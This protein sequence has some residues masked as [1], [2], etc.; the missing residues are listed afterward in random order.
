[1][2]RTLIILIVALVAV[3]AAY[4][5]FTKEEVVFSKETSLYKAVPVSAPVFVEVSS[6]RNVPPEN[7]VLGELS[8]FE[9]V[10]NILQKVQQS[11]KAI[12]E[13]KEIQGSWAK[14]PLILAFDFVGEDKIQPV[15]ISKIR[16]ADELEGF[17][18][19]LGE[20]M[21]NPGQEP[22]E[23]KY[24][25]HKIFSVKNAEGK[26]LSYCAARGLILLSPEAILIEK[27]LRQ[28]NSE[29]LTDIHNFNKVNKTVASDTDVAW[30]INHERFPELLA[31]V[32]NAKTTG[33]TNE[34]G[35]TVKTNLRRELLDTK[36]YA[37]WSE[38]DMRFDDENISLAGIT[39]ADD[40]LNHFVTIFSGQS[41][42]HCDAG[43]ILP[44]NAS[45]YLGITFSDRDLFFKNLLEF[46][47][48]SNTFYKR[49]ELLKK[50]ER[51]LGPDSRET[52]KAM[53]KNEV[54]AALTDV[55]AEG[56]PGSLFI[57]NLNSRKNSQENFESLLQNYANSKKIDLNSLISPVPAGNGKTFRVY[58][59]P[60]PS[61]PGVWL[62]GTFKFAKARYATFYDDYLVFASSQK[63]MQEYLAD[64]ELDYTLDEDN[65]YSNFISSSEGKANISAY[66]NIDRLF[67]LSTRLFNAET[68][69]KLESLRE[70][71]QK[72]LLLGWQVVCEKNVYFN[73]FNL[74][75]GKQ[76]SKSDG[77]LWSCNLGAEV[78]TKPQLVE[79]A[80]NPAAKNIIVQD[81]DNRLHLV[82]SDG[83]LLWTIPVSGR[84]MGEIHEVDQFRNGKWQYL[85]NTRE[86]LYLIDRNGNNVAGFPVTFESPATNGVSAFDYDNN[87][88]YRYFLAFENRKVLALDQNG[89][90]VNGWNFD[91]TE[92]AVTTP[93]QHFR[94]NNKDY[95]VFKDAG[96]IYIQDRRGETRVK[97]PVKFENSN[98]PLVLGMNATP[99]IVADD[100]NGT[101]HY[102][103]FD[104]KSAEKNVG[105]FGAGHFFTAG[106]LDGNN[107]P[108]FVFIDGNKLE[109]KDENGKMLYEEKLGN[110]INLAPA[111]YTFSARQKKVGIT[112]S[113][114][115]RI[116]LFGPNGNQHNGFPVRGNSQFSIGP[117][118]SGQL[119]LVA[120]NDDELVCYALK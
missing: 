35:E 9:I 53:V 86:K 115:K 10:G 54:I 71:W 5:L 95:I 28:L 64:M 41:P 77:R 52:L 46:F 80:D 99:K 62:G 14:R 58:E 73:A 15:I 110:E 112:D 104:G 116:Y 76:P 12:S 36:N 100:K 3:A 49:E 92:S 96:K 75:F 4:I 27:G 109:V 55:S 108:D 32:M 119:N 103:Y 85:F 48:L 8:G 25:G 22:A 20:L 19:L 40:S 60:F 24:S 50:I 89:K 18:K 120:G 59:F 29:N 78:A 97:T 65:N 82:S 13:G 111:I 102:L 105:G 44:R 81:E 68:G 6:I 91:K 37:S 47:R 57:I 87:H 69:K 106:D 33:T 72:S 11:E 90:P 79:N 98:N 56:E 66:A 23:R 30:Y 51:R 117:V 45:F 114:N 26:N 93:V 21:G 7:P 113:K 16:N 39:A 2:K 70:T 101:V 107:I 63:V 31:R 118:Q 42:G 17:Q 38:L 1:M 74:G 34:F 94:I 84:I 61:L 43:R 88:K 67:P 83:K